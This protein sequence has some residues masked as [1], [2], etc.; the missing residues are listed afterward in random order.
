MTAMLALAPIVFGLLAVSALFSAA[1]TSMTG[2]SRAR[3]HQLE[4]EGDR[5]ARRVN[6]LLADQE[7]MIGSVLL[8]NNLI[9]ILSSALATQVLTRSI[10]GALGVAIATA[11]MTVLVLVFAEVLPKTLAILRSDDVARFL[12]WPTIVVVRAFGP[13]IYAIQWVIRK[14]LGLFGFKMSME[15]DVLAAHEEIRGAVEYHHSEGLV[16]SRDRWMLG[17]VL[18]LAQLDVSEVMVHR[19]SIDMLDAGLA[20][21]ALIDA[22]LESQH[23]R[24]PLYREN[25]ENI[26]GVLHVKDLLQ[27]MADAGGDMEKIQIDA[28]LRE[29]WFVPETTSL[30]DQLAAFLKRK[31]H[32]ALVVD[33]Y[34]ALQGLVTLEDILEEIV[35][36]IEDEYDVDVSGVKAGP[37]GSVSVDGA[38]TIRELNRAMNWDLP[39]DEAVTVAGLLIAEAQT[40]P[41]VGQT[42]GVYGHRFTVVARKGNQI[43]RLEIAP[44]AKPVD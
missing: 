43:T 36:E 13:V 23:T 27:A 22:A 30:K 4:R 6:K 42:F 3:M 33:E 29:P 31:T 2:A 17:G 25:S 12:S 39:D 34:G 19:K 41:E 5:A 38:V 37:D 44:A 8:G 16:E 15:M 24:L 1:E 11:V 7:T 14:T 26:V 40:I 21:K 28:I 18:D 35:G 20:P 10:P 9:N 32:F